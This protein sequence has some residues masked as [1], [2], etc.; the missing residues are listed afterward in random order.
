MTDTLESWNTKEIQNDQ[1]RLIKLVSATLL[2]EPQ[3]YS[4]ADGTRNDILDCANAIANKAAATAA[5]SSSS[6]SKAGS[7]KDGSDGGAS[8]SASPAE[9]LLKIALYVR[10][11]LNIRSTANFLLAIAACNRNSAC[12]LSKYFSASVRLPSDMFEVIAHAKALARESG[13]GG[14]MPSVLRNAV[15]RKFAEFD[16]YQLAKYNN[17]GKLRRKKLKEKQAA[18]LEKQLQDPKIAKVI[19]SIEAPAA[20]AASGGR[21]AKGGKPAKKASGG[22][23]GGGGGRPSLPSFK[24]V[25][26]SFHIG[27]PKSAVMSILGKKYPRTAEEFEKSGLAGR[28]EA[29]MAGK[30]MRLP[31]PKTWETELSE[32]G[33]NKESWAALI[34]SNKL[35]FMAMLKN[36]RNIIL[37]G[38]DDRYHDWII[39]GKLTNEAAVKAS[40]QFPFR[41]LAAYDVIA[42]LEKGKLESDRVSRAR[43]A[44]S[45]GWADLPPLADRI[46]ETIGRIDRALS[47]AAL[48]PLVKRSLESKKRNLE[49]RCKMLEKQGQGEGQGQEDPDAPKRAP[50]SQALLARYKAAIDTAIKLAIATNV[51]PLRGKT[52]TMSDIS[53]SMQRPISYKGGFGS[54]VNAYDISILLSLMLNSVCQDCDFYL[55]GSTGACRKPYFKIDNSVKDS[56]ILGAMDYCRKKARS[57]LTAGNEFFYGL[58]EEWIEKKYKVDRMVIFSGWSG[59]LFNLLFLFAFLS[60]SFSFLSISF[61]FHF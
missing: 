22:S 7:E 28:F 21:R 52:V 41:F 10:D 11:D 46:R 50:P 54:I 37:A 4:D 36:L 55:F 45:R 40:R 9:F 5:A 56:T 15:V 1:L 30:R 18:L 53:G 31:I 42:E 60:I 57:E 19:K 27:E 59:N 20:E 43:G 23:D 3:Y 12:F 47:S 16:E 8:A 26:R 49:H 29:R 39:E 32:K 34:D 24:S 6:S 33:N 38:M 14:G 35:P 13:G 25:I 51:P 17:E 44:V 61:S 58:F 48:T 2:Y